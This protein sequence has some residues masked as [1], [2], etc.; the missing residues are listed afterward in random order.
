MYVQQVGEPDRL[1]HRHGQGREVGGIGG[2]RLDE[3]LALRLQGRAEGFVRAA[4]ALLEGPDD[5]HGLLR[6]VGRGRG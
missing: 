1:L 4:A 2:R 5:E 6:I 3:R